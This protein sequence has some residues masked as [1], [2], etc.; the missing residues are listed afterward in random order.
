MD[1]GSEPRA[2]K[3]EIVNENV[4][5]LRNKDHV[6][7][8]CN[9]WLFWQVFRLSLFFQIVVQVRDEGNGWIVGRTGS[10][11]GAFPASYVEQLRNNGPD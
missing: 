8:Y 4:P 9:G 1:A 10:V 6:I 5:V 7:Y 11:E 2:F 3:L